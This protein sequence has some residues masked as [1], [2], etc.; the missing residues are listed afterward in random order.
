MAII[1][2]HLPKTAGTSFGVSLAA[3]FGDRFRGDNGDQAIA[4]PLT[5][6]WQQATSAGLLLAAQGLGDVACVHGHFLPAKYLPLGQRCELTFVTWMRDPVA[7]MVSHYH[8]WQR[9]YDER[10]AAPHH[11]RV[12][13]EGWSLQRFC[14]SQ[15]FRNIYTQYLWM[16]PLE[17]FSFIGISEYFREDFEEFS[18]QYLATVLPHQHHNATPRSDAYIDLDAAFLDTV[19]DFHAADM[20]LYAKALRLRRIRCGRAS[21]RELGEAIS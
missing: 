16:F 4:K 1:S 14:L 6:R 11:R 5:E 3:H 10:I 20:E 17:K 18:K 7:R 13:E 12:I 21:G 2:V 8:Y 9:S 19:R 15:E